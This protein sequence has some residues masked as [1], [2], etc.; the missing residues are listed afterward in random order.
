MFA[1]AYTILPIFALIVVGNLLR[2]NEFPGGEFWPMAD[3]LTYWVLFPALLFT[4]STTV[5]I[6]SAT[7]GPFALALVAGFTAAGLV[8]IVGMRL[9]GLSGPERGSIF[10]GAVRHNTFIA[11]A[12]AEALFGAEGLLAAALATA[13]LG[14]I[15]NFVCVPVLV[16]FRGGDGLGKVLLREL[17]RNPLLIAIAAGLTLNLTGIGPI[18]VISDMG[19]LLSVAALPVA[20]L[21]VGAGLRV[22][23]IREA[24]GAVILAS[25]GKLIVFPVA[26]L[27]VVLATGLSGTYAHVAIIF[28]AVPT[29]VSGYSLARQLGADAELMAGIITLETLVAVISLPLSLAFLFSF[30]S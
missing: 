24:G 1:I 17:S 7:V 19:A 4:K 3:K 27:L 23:A 20:L 29:A 26:L 9:M 6:D 18:P 21:C 10:Q 14:P 25:V 11:F 22:H 8:A 30:L 5:P 15:T 16:L 28:G 12:V 13:I 2:R